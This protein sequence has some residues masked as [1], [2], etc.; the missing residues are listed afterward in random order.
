VRLRARAGQINDFG[1]MRR[2]LGSP[3]MATDLFAPN[4]KPHSAPPLDFAG[5][6]R[7]REPQRCRTTV[8]P[9]SSQAGNSIVS[10]LCLRLNHCTS[11]YSSLYRSALILV[12]LGFLQAWLLYFVEPRPEPSLILHRSQALPQPGTSLLDKQEGAAA[13]AR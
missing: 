12:L 4:S 1:G 9:K 8:A 3:L 2:L 5:N 11:F 10:A 6:Q 7:A 13:V